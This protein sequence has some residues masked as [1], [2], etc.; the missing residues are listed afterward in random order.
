MLDE[1]DETFKEVLTSKQKIKR[2]EQVLTHSLR[3][4]TYP[5]SKPKQRYTRKENYGPVYIYKALA[6]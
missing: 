6:N 5:D 2:R 1:L 4:A 3:P